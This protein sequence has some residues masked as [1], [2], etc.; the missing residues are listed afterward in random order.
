[1]T[2]HKHSY[3]T[4]QYDTKKGGLRCTQQGIFRR[5]SALKRCLRSL[6][7]ALWIMYKRT[8]QSSAGANCSTANTEMHCISWNVKV[9]TCV[10]KNQ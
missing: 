10:H 1:M 5:F 9:H 4:T 7:S 8:L 3:I 2:K 6:H